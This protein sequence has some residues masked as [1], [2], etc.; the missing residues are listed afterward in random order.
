MI[1]KSYDELSK[2]PTFIE[3]FNYLKLNGSVGIQT[4][5]SERYLNQALYKCREWKSIRNKVIIRDNGC[6]IGCDDRPIS[7][8]ILVHHINPI[9]IDD[10]L[11]RRSCVFDEQNLICVSHSTHNA[12]HYSDARQLIEDYTE[13]KPN[14][15]S[16]WKRYRKGD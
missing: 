12:I 9:T 16:P 8:R 1:T 11:N 2:L 4:F 10:V 15:T 13:R 14:D 7:D 6:D 5:G 3:R